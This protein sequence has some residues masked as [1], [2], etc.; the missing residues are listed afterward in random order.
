MKNNII[1][2]LTLATFAILTIGHAKAQDIP[3]EVLSRSVS[4]YTAEMSRAS[5]SN[6]QDNLHRFYNDYPS[7]RLKNS[8]QMGMG[9]PGWTHILLFLSS[10]VEPEISYDHSFSD[11]LLN[12]RYYSG[13]TVTIPAISLEYEY[14]IKRWFALGVKGVVGIQTM[15]DRH[16]GTN[17]LFHRYSYIVASGLLNM[18]FSWLHRNCVSMYSSLGLGL[19][20]HYDNKSY[21]YSHPIVDVT[22]VGI[23]VGKGFYGFAEVGGFIGGVVRGGVGFR[24]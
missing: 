14:S 21:Y 24:F 7:V 20:S 1:K 5:N 2:A 16:V 10:D 23:H 17:E 18:R 3:T 12:A 22:W 19:S 4:S 13:K 15:P 8:V 9:T 6:Y 11:R